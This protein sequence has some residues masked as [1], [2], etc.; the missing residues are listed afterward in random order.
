M[1]RHNTGRQP[2]SEYT[3]S[4][5]A[6]REVVDRAGPPRPR[7]HFL[8]TDH[9]SAEAVAAYVDGR[10]PNAGRVRADA[11]LPLCPQC[12]REVDEQRDVR[13][14]LRGSGPIR[15]PQDLLQRLRSLDQTPPP[16]PVDRRDGRGT[17]WSRLLHRLRRFGH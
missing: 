12:S 2:T 13:H 17:G 14:A 5:A 9:L 1:D 16:P 4:H 10:L 3:L 11:H 8:S 7:P 6:A 15:M